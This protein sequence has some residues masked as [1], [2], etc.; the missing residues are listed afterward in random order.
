MENVREY[1][2][3]ENIK[4][5]LYSDVEVYKQMFFMML[6]RCYEEAERERTNGT[7]MRFNEAMEKL[8]KELGIKDRLIYFLT[9]NSPENCQY[10]LKI[11]LKNN[12]I[13]L[14][15]ISPM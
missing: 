1:R 13:L 12:F 7:L 5:K 3:K 15:K 6:D 8:F 10:F 14:A 2:L 9:T 4:V 11:S